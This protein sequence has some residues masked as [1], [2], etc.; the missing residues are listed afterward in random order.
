MSS[1][2]AIV[3]SEVFLRRLTPAL[4]SF[5]GRTQD[6]RILSIHREIEELEPILAEINP[7]GLI[8][9]WLPQKT[10]QLLGLKLS[11]PH[12]IVATHKCYPNV[13]S[14]D[15]DDLAV[16]R[17]AA[18]AL[19]MVGFKSLACLGNGTPYSN[20]RIQ[21][22]MDTISL[23]EIPFSRHTES[24]FEEL[25]Y[26]E[27]FTKP[28]QAMK[29]WLEAL[30]K[31]CGIFAVHDPLG[32]FLSGACTQLGIG[33]PDEVAIIGAN[34]DPLVCGLTFPMLSS[35]SIPWNEV[36]KVVGRS[37]QEMIL[38]QKQIT[39]TC[40]LI[41]PSGVVLRHSANHLAIQDNMLRRSMS[42]M[43][44][45][46]K[47]PISIGTLCSHLNISRRTLE[48]KFKEI[49]CCTPWEMLCQI[50]VNHAKQLLSAT[51]HPISRVAELS[52]FNDPERMAVVFKRLTG[53]S[54]SQ[55]RK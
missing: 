52:G 40:Q 20:L 21:G 11:I 8:T 22:F 6:Y 1:P 25:R 23:K 44:E 18:E 5:T 38:G 48:R 49:L 14:I 42:Y 51:V 50:R 2:I 46:M 19:S 43:T 47:E 53:K 39:H 9:E 10:D 35:V 34:N 16:G 55:F 27:S 15:V 24:G 7:S 33:V 26:S 36:G 12:I 41:S 32:R 3:M 28:T 4:S 45:R 37:M 31:P 17:E 30:P 29:D 54:P 13:L